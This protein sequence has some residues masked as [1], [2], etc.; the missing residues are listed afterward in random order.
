M[1]TG[2][3]GA[4]GTH[5]TA[6]VWPFTG[7]IRQSASLPASTAGLPTAVAMVCIVATVAGQRGHLP[8]PDVSLHPADVVPTTPS[9]S[10]GQRAASRQR[11]DGLATN[12]REQC[13]SGRATQV[14]GELDAV[15]GRQ[16]VR[17]DAAA[18]QIGDQFDDVEA[19]AQVHAALA[20]FVAQTD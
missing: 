11:L 7:D 4:P 13:R 15:A 5:C 9:S 10:S 16:V 8:E 3:V 14:Q 6:L 1:P 2:R 19:E 20:A 17:F 12:V 18:V